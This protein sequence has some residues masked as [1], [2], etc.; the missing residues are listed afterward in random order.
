MQPESATLLGD[1]R[2]LLIET[3]SPEETFEVGRRLGAQLGRGMV[4]ALIGDLGAGKTQL[5]KGIASGLNVRAYVDSPAF[6]I[7][8]EYQG[9]LRLC[10][11]DFYRLDALAPEDYYWL[12][13][14]LNSDAVCVIEWADRFLEEIFH[15]YLRVEIA[16]GVEEQIRSMRLA[17]IGALYG[18]SR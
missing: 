11:M 15:E 16:A 4:V 12:D 9:D 18:G 17:G 7:I 14:Y 6:D 10:H 13:E 2:G 8:H 5:A 1:D 3:R